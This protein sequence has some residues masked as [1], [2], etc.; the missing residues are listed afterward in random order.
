MWLGSCNR[1][2]TPTQQQQ[3]GG[4]GSR[5]HGD[6]V[7]ITGSGFPSSLPVFIFAGGL[8][9]ELES[10]AVGST[11][12]F[13]HNAAH[14]PSGIVGFNWTRWVGND[15]TDAVIVNDSIRGNVIGRTSSNA[16]GDECAQA[17]TLPAAV[18]PGGK[19]MFKH[20]SRH[21][22]TFYGDT[23][24]AQNKLIR[25]C[26]TDDITDTTHV[27]IITYQHLNGGIL[28]QTNPLSSGAAQDTYYAGTGSNLP[29]VE[30]NTWRYYTC[31]AQLGTAGNSDGQ[32]YFRT[33]V[34]GSPAQSF[35]DTTSATNTSHHL[36]ANWNQLYDGTSVTAVIYQNWDGNGYGNANWAVDDHFVQ[37]GSYAC[38]ELWDTNDPS[39]VTHKEIQ[40]PTSWSSTSI[41]VK[42]NQG[43]FSAGTAY[44]V[45]LDDTVADTVLASLQITI[46][47]AGPG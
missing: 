15:N 39:T 34:A 1:G 31:K 10:T 37:V 5:N 28:F 11:P 6:S 38:V 14:A 2:Y 20:W 26:G 41:T 7:T 42:L 30:D 23:P 13:G 3:G 18:G 16:S 46:G 44:L 33:E 47:S 9:G 25:I 4:G 8:G 40:Q 12:N 17:A 36:N 22:N 35:F 27:T 24:N 43:S 19:F 21:N 29:P 45:V 32:L